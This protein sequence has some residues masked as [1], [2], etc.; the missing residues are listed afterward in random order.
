MLEVRSNAERSEELTDHIVELRKQID[1][2]QAAEAVALQKWDANKVWTDD[3]SKSAGHRFSRESWS[4]IAACKR[5]VH[6]A[7]R[8]ASMPLTS[9]AFN[10]GQVSA[11]R[12]DQ[13]VM[14]NQSDVEELFA[15]DEHVLIEQARTLD[16]PR[17]I[18]ACNYWR[19]MA[20]EFRKKG[21]NEKGQELRS[22][23]VSRTL[24]GAVDIRGLLDPINGE[25]FF[26]SLSK[27]EDEFFHADWKEAQQRLGDD[28]KISDLLR[29]PA[30]R[31]ADALVEMA[32]RAHS[33]KP[34]D[35]K[36][37]PLL[38]IMV[39]ESTFSKICE[40]ASG[41]V[42]SNGQLIPLLDTTRIERIVFDGPSRVM[43][44][45]ETRSFRGALS[46]AIRV[47]DGSCQ[48][49]SVCDVPAAQCELD[50]DEAW[51]LGGKTIEANGKCLCG[52]HNRKKGAKP[53][54]EPPPLDE[55]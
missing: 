36:P 18:K 28:I 47:R 27:I 10:S 4:S 22:L 3:G 35:R 55:D 15:R 40:T 45:G 8:L 20:D 1:L 41:T 23:F 52:F 6:R 2:L 9:E 43:D 46:R 32:L 31:R 53:R 39:G 38:S 37:E 7:K 29:T 11:D 49:S 51:S 19:V 33:Y 42:L 25:I 16:W 50:H 30:Q 5:R 48:D 21:L 24:D 17:F 34:G 44:V 13:L 12:V 26:N 14:L 54:P